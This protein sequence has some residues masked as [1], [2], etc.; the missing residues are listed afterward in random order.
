MTASAVYTTTTSIQVWLID[1]E[2]Q[3]NGKKDEKGGVAGEGG[4]GG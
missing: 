3:K 2:D 4:G 1:Q